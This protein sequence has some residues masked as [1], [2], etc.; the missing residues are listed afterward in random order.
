MRFLVALL[1]FFLILP[2]QAQDN[3]E[4]ADRSWLVGML[5]DQL[6]TPNRQFRINGIQGAL[7]SNATIGEISIAD[8]QGVWL[9]IVNARIVWTRSALLLGRLNIDQLGA[10]RIEVLRKPLPDESLPAPEAGGFQLPE[11][12]VSVNLR[13]L[14]VERVTFGQDVFGLASEMS[15][16]GRVSLADGSLDAA[17][18]ITRLDG[19]GGKLTLATTYAN[20]TRQLALDLKLDEPANGIVANL[21]SVDGRPPMLLTVNGA[22]PLDDLKVALTLD[23]DGQRVLTGSTDLARRSE[24]LGFNA[25]LEG[26]ISRLI[27]P[28]FREFFGDDTRL[29]A[30][31]LVPDA[32][33]FV[34]ESL[35]LTSAALSLKAALETTPDKFLRRVSINADIA[36]GNGKKVVLPV[37]GGQTKVTRAQ[38][39]VSYG[40]NADNWTGKLDIDA[41]ETGAFAA[42]N[43]VVD[44]GGDALNLDDPASRRVTFNAKGAATGIT[45]TRADV[46][47]ALGDRIDLDIQGAWQ[48]G[49]P[50][51][52]A[53]AMLTGNGLTA[54]L[55]G[56]VADYV[57]NG[58]IGLQAASITPFGTLA[59]RDLS[60]ALDLKAKG[61]VTPIGGGFD[62]VLDGTGNELR[63]GTPAVDNVI[64]GET[65]ITGRVARG[66]QGLVAQNLK[67]ANAQAEIL[68]DGTYATGA[69]DF[70]LNIML[71]D[72][73]LL[74]DRA[75]G[76]LTAKGRA[77]GA[78]GVIKL[79]FAAEV[80]Q[81]TLVG[82]SLTG[83]KVTFLG[84]ARNGG[85]D[86]KIGGDAFLD[87]NRVSL[88]SN[89]ASAPE[90]KALTDLNFQA[91]GTT[92]T[93]NVKQGASGL[94][95]GKLA[96]KSA[97]LS[98]VAAL[99]LV[100]A[101]GAAQADISLQA[102]DGK[103][104]AA[105]KGSIQNLVADQARV[106]NAQIEATLADLLNV[107]II[108]GSLEA[109]GV[110]AS[111]IDINK[112]SANAQ[113]Q[114][115][116]TNFNANAAL[117]NG[118]NVATDGSLAP[119]SGGYRV[120]LSKLDLAQ[121]KL[122]ANLAEP[123]SVL[124]QGQ[125]VTIDAFT[126][127]AGGGRVAVKGGVA[128]NLGLDVNIRA[129]PLAL[130]NA[131]KP[132]LALGGTLDGTATIGGTR[133][134]P[135]IQFTVNGQS[136][137]AAV[138]RQAGLSTLSVNAKGNSTTSRL[139][140]DALVTSPEGLKATASG[141]VPLDKGQ[142]A[143]DVN[144]NA[145]PLAVLNAVAKGQGLGG[146]VSGT[147]HV[148]GTLA[149][150]A[151]TF[152]A[153]GSGLRATALDNAGLSPLELNLSGRFADRTVHLN[154]ANVAGPQS[155]NL[156]ASGAIPL[157]GPGLSVSVKG[158]A[159][160]ALA[161]RFLAE[162]GAQAAG[163]ITL[164]ASATGSISQPQLRGMFSTVGASF[165]DPESNL[166]LNDI[167]VMGSLDG[168]R[169]TLRN[170][171]AALASG[172]R[173]SA[174]GSISTNAAQAFPSDIT[175][176]LDK[177]RYADGNMLI[178]TVN[179][180]LRLSGSLTRDPMLSGRID[181]D[182]AEI[183]VPE[184]LGG[185]AADINVKHID[186]SRAVEATL[187]RAK[188]ND[189][190][191]VPTARPSVLRLNIALNAPNQI[192]VRGRGLDAELGG[193]LQLTGPATAIEP[194]GGFKMIRGRLGILG[195]RITFDEGT[196]TL[197]GDLDPFLD[198]VAR[199]DGNDITVFITVRG[200]VSA[201][202]ISFSSQ[203][204]LPEDEVLA[205]L[206]FKRGINELSPL[207]IAQLAAAAAEL[208]GGSN[209]S[210]LGSLRN[211][212]GLDD[213]DV[214]TDSKGN[215]AVRAGRY[216]Q[217][218]I[219]LGVEAGAGG[220]TRGTVN[221]DIT[222]NL[223]AK[224]AV[225]SDGDSSVGVFYE[226]DY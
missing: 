140:L 169:I 74:S 170:A 113:S 108:N 67:I 59:G 161:N 215:A 102:V 115:D 177:A 157:S 183:T 12:P 162:R 62:L 10:E 92:I 90:G 15:V 194:V 47:E 51:E 133:S 58:D 35:D 175:I 137:T 223:K 38:F 55:S 200:R 104:Q 98:T 186:A 17:L 42:K 91:G 30:A 155:F 153:R 199:S 171:S 141:A 94:L 39:N 191:P 211:A 13:N 164:S 14:A 48:S 150:P 224:G 138:L 34:L 174:T 118:T 68:A 20:S 63:I 89:V 70:N 126:L 127:N 166:R 205:R 6:S 46:A 21:L 152:D 23:A 9:R 160:L 217:D 19:P 53:K 86:G 121:G 156:Q 109:S 154:S 145:F 27:S 222:D 116:T 197:V 130:A 119:E 187:K 178:A 79:D 66:E 158:D 190:T 181:V 204:Q 125:N 147:A 111:G 173:I 33:G 216:I 120:K 54:A 103:Q 226:K 192:F 209:T 151:A 64:Q 60:G 41:L 49:Q 219:Y 208:A 132:D 32:G 134:T 159:P 85:V 210:L 97:D 193:S 25:N 213:L 122:T 16:T 167:A 212:T 57:F 124:V 218:N 176:N 43:V 106:A 195:Q 40:E 128:E 50:V 77:D 179:G 142:M 1:M 180:V 84:L 207:Q 184:S 172:G 3:S 131:I 2:A 220:T 75:S 139:N 202:N 143:L 81:G 37:A 82:K 182:R 65:R 117:K 28:V 61:T 45:A 112:L 24:G 146:T 198:F 107:P 96:L 188:A 5:E 88:S 71:A 203:P 101:T 72:L 206:I 18:D 144:L 83:G 123:A 26:P 129:L 93:G 136:L 69:A 52:I 22:G 168:D 100:Q 36:D 114:G 56:T 225:G 73:A 149:K 31:G 99:M 214:V 165:V 135:E 7:S 185:A 8:R 110:S 148:T 95:D 189:G 44:L 76:R 221:L 80:P 29:T 196:V 201:L 4:Q 11:L 163:N 87:G 78:D 105:I